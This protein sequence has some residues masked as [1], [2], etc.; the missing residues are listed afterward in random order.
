MKIITQRDIIKN[1]YIN[2]KRQYSQFELEDDPELK[3]A[4]TV[5]KKLK[6]LNLNKATKEEI[7]EIMGNDCWTSVVCDE[8]NQPTNLAVEF[9]TG[10]FTATICT[11]C[12]I[13]SLNQLMEKLN[14]FNTTNI[15][16]Q[17]NRGR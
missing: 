12:L 7:D 3:W 8:C 1:V 4:K 10:H 2:W 6:K 11:N 9:S 5:R 14:E 13:E 17:W 15:C 16:R